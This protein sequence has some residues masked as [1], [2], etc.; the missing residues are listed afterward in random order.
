MTKNNLKQ[1]ILDTAS[2][3]FYLNGYNT[4][5]INEIIA[6]AQIAKATLYHHFRSKEEIA[7]AYLDL[8]HEHFMQSLQNMVENTADKNAKLLTVFDY[9]RHLFRKEGF[10]GCWNQ[11]MIGELPAKEVRARKKIQQQKLEFLDYLIELTTE[12]TVQLSKAEIEKIAQGIYLLYEAAISASHIH[13]SDWPIHSAK[14]MASNLI[15]SEI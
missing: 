11:K 12:N 15:F 9:L 4:T 2:N 6:K 5:G 3:L 10:Q 13:K 1:H 7:L 8:K 14:I